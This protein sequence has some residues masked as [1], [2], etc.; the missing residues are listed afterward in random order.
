MSMVRIPTV[1]LCLIARDEEDKIAKALATAGVFDSALV[2]DT[3]SKDDTVQIAKNCGA[4]VEYFTWIDDFAAARNEW[5]KHTDADWIFW[6]DCDDEITTDTACKVVDW[7]RSQDE[8]VV[9][10]FFRY[11]YPT[12]FAVDHIRL[13]RHGVPWR[14]RIHEYLDFSNIPGKIEVT[15]LEVLHSGYPAYNTAELERKSQRN[16]RLLLQELKADPKNGLILQYIAT[17]FLARG[18]YKKCI[19]YMDRAIKC[20]IGRSDYSWLPEA[21]V[22]LARCHTK[23]GRKHKARKILERGMKLYPDQMP[24]SIDRHLKVKRLDGTSNYEYG[25]HRF[26][27]LQRIS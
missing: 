15:H 9:G 3:G 11:V 22:V 26:E 24:R 19:E 5:L 27:Q 14:Q 21:Y 4:R 23:L 13:Y 18:M 12:D 8:S 16:M 6:L 20:S 17:D 7:A 2:L 10:G 25:K 1:C